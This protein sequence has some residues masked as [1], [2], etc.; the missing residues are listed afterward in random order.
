MK[1]YQEK[2]KVS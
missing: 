2:M 1:V